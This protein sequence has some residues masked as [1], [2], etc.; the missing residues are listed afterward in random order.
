M[1]FCCCKEE[2]KQQQY[3]H[4]NINKYK[5]GLESN[6]N[7]NFILHLDQRSAMGSIAI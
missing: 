4:R 3:R 2:K 1:S 6:N 5:P 7:K